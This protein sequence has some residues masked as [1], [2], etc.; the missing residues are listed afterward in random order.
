M[1]EEIKANYNGTFIS[2]GNLLAKLAITVFYIRGYL[3]I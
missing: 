3:C 1:L 2:L